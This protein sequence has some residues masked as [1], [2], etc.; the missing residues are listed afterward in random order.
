MYKQLYPGDELVKGKLEKLLSQL[1][2]TV[3]EY[4]VHS[5]IH[6]NP[7]KSSYGLERLRFLRARG[8]NDRF[9]KE[10]RLM[11][12]QSAQFA[13]VEQEEMH[14][15]LLIEQERVNYLAS[16]NQRR[17]DLNIP[18]VL[19]KLDWYYLFS[20][21]EYVL[22][23]LAQGIHVALDKAAAR[24]LLEDIEALPNKKGFLR[25]PVVHIYF[26]MLCFLVR[27]GEDTEESLESIRS[28]LDSVE[29]A[30]TVDQRKML[31]GL[32][33]LQVARLVNT[34]G[35]A[36]LPKAFSDLLRSFDAWLSVLREPVNPFHFPESRYD[37]SPLKA[38]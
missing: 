21:M 6:S 36:Y 28:T 9:E 7:E 25:I 22:V 27:D 15:H 2:Q 18:Q 37:G 11:D 16:L 35:N 4:L 8:L 5:R 20:R 32:V 34:V 38:I 26:R 13:F 14:L 33:R 3:W 12:R 31:F 29:D 1:Q 30:L 19:E 17:S 10:L 23:F 24:Q